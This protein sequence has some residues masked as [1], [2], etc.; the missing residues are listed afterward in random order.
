MRPASPGHYLSGLDL[1]GR[2]VVVVGAGTVAARR[3][4][5][6]LSAGAD[7]VVVAPAAT[8]AVEGMAAGGE[9]G[10]RRRPYRGG[11][12]D[13]AW[14]ALACTSD[15]AVNEQVCRDAERLRVFCVRADRG[16]A[17]SAVTPATGMHEGLQVGVLAGGRPRRSAAVRDGLLAALRSGSVPDARELGSPVSG[18]AAAAV[19]GTAAA[20]GAPP[21]VALVGAGPGDPD[22]ITVRGR[23]LLARAD[24][25]VADRLA[26]RELLDTLGP[27]VE[28]IDA[29]KLPYGRAASQDEINATLVARARAG[30]FVVRLKGGDPYLFGRG[31]EELQA[32]LAAGV[33]VTVVPGLASA[34]AVPTAA[35]VPV[36]YRGMA[37]EVV[38]VSGHLDPGDPASLVSWPEL[39]RLSGTIVLLMAVRRIGAIAAALL[40]GGRPAH[41]PVAVVAE[42]TRPG[43]RTLRSTL[44]AVA[45]DI[46]AAGIRPPAVIVVGPVAG[47]DGPAGLDN[48]A[49]GF[50]G[51]AGLG[52][53]AGGP[54]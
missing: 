20:G 5:R 46:A 4:P 43:E 29:A 49:T 6:L 10:W 23:Q 11:D 51:P 52:P 48:P 18:A 21:G 42:G 32:C 40:D 16:A 12:L 45:G 37:H 35:G 26:P 14:Y 31:Y 30:K 28:L 34:F 53:A 2:R 25:V 24:V 47:L 33:P 41:T 44:C 38:V 19:A 36:T 1:A 9:L 50:G 15:P 7:V 39:A 3:L 27:H 22:L 54:P 8:T 17:G 13:G